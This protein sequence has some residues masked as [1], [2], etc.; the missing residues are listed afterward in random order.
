MQCLCLRKEKKKTDVCP[1][2]HKNSTKLSETNTGSY[3]LPYQIDRRDSQSPPQVSAM[4]THSCGS[5][6][7]HG[8]ALALPAPTQHPASHHSACL[9]SC[10]HTTALMASSCVAV[11]QPAEV[12]STSAWLLARCLPSPQH[13][14]PY[15]QPSYSPFVVF[16]ELLWLSPNL[17]IFF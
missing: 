17:A 7:E 13:H 3:F 6:P 12:F 14:L 8:Q 11:L 9:P 16:T 10:S 4:T 2:Q 1:R 5:K 15:S